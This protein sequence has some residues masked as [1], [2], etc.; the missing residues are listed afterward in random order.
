METDAMFFT[1]DSF[2]CKLIEMK[3]SLTNTLSYN[4]YS[5]KRAQVHEKN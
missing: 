1:V 3:S 5:N 4:W 2:R